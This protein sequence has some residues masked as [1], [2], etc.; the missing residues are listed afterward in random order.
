MGAED[1]F[2]CIIPALYLL[3]K[4]EGLDFYEKLYHEV[5]E[6]VRNG[7]GVISDERYRLA[8]FGIPLWFNLGIF[9][10]L[11]SLGAIVVFEQPYYVGPFVEIDLEDPFEGLVQRIWKKACWNHQTG[12]EAKPEISNPS[13]M[14]AVGSKFIVQL[15]GGHSID[16]AL[17]HRSHTCRATSWGQVHYQRIMENE[18]I[19]THIFESDMADPR[20]WSDARIKSQLEAFIETVEQ[21][22]QGRIKIQG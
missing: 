4:E 1:Y 11:E 10:Y 3:G 16:G 5:G 22:K 20:A 13:S 9:N 17:F 19:P 18:G 14:V 7:V 15:I 8:F 21:S 6:R 2:A 12:V